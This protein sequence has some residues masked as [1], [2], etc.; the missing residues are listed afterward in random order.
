MS[1]TNATTLRLRAIRPHPRPVAGYH[2]KPYRVGAVVRFYGE[3]RT[4]RRPA[5][6]GWVP[7]S[8]PQRR[9][10]VKAAQRARRA[11]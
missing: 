10:A 3:R 5:V 7:R 6:D 4:F 9:R 2:F 1:T 11:S 8:A